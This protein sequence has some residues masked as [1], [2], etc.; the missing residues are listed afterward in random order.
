MKFLRLLSLACAFSL[1]SPGSQAGAGAPEAVSLPALP[2]GQP[3]LTVRGPRAE[4]KFS[5]AQLEALGTH[6]VRTRTFWP[7]DDGSYEGVLLSSLL[8]QAGI[9]GAAAIRIRARDGFSQVMPRQ[10]WEKWPILLA[11]RRDGQ[12]IPTRNKGPLRIIYPRD[13]SPEL[14]DTL[15]RL[16][17]VWLVDRIEPADK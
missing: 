11:T 5:L 13:M 4:H 15:Y 1:I 2:A 17:W 9:E 10:D 12:P 7:D 8:K 16:R 14:A 6:R 3:V